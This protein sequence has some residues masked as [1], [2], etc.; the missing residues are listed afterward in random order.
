[1][2]V[3]AAKFVLEA[4]ENIPYMCDIENVVFDF[5]EKAIA[6]MQLGKATEDEEL[7]LVPI[8]S[9]RVGS[10]GVMKYNCFRYIETRILDEVKANLHDLDGIYL[11]LHGAS[12][13]ENI[14][15]GDHHILKE[16]RKIVGPYLPIVVACDPHGNLCK[17]YVENTQLIRSYR[18]SP[19]TDVE[20]TNEFVLNQLKDLIRNRQNIHSVYRKLPMIL[21][22]EQSVSTDEP[23]RTINK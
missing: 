7:E 4:N 19:H 17:E 20:Q 3:L 1:M 10:N 11:H 23:V 5:N 2:K 8:L 13:I 15:S 6:A 18:E 22:G 14:G 21:G 16:I 9:A 12:E